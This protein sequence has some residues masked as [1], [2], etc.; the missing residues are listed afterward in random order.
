[1]TAEKPQPELQG[2]KAPHHAEALT[3]DPTKR[4]KPTGLLSITAVQAKGLTHGSF[5]SRLDPLEPFLVASLNTR[6]HNP[7]LISERPLDATEIDTQYQVAQR[8]RKSPGSDPIWNEKIYFVIYDRLDKIWIDVYDKDWKGH[9][10][11]GQAVLDL[12]KESHCTEWLKDLWIP[13]VDAKGKN[14]EKGTEVHLLVHFEPV[15]VTEYLQKKLNRTIVDIKSD[16][17]AKIVNQVMESTKTGAQAYLQNEK[18]NA[19]EY[20]H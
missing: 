18:A 8:T 1:M 7:A 11:L 10:E 4:G 2:H 9:D 13:L 3:V 15:T 6:P 16:I 12:S 5:L 17:A 20:G 19:L 14:K